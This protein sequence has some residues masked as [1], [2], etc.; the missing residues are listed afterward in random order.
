[1]KQEPLKTWYRL[2]LLWLGV[3][4]LLLWAFTRTFS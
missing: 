4:I 2:S 3:I 1:M